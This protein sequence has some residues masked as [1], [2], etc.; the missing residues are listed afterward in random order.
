MIPFIFSTN[1]RNY[2][3]VVVQY[4]LDLRSCSAYLRERLERSFM[5]NRT[6]RP[7]SAIVLDQTIECSISKYVYR[8]GR[9]N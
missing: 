6:N 8:K 4:L 3:E 5:V 9:D 7:F 1:H 2:A